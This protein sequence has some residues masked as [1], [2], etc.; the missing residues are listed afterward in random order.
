[1]ANHPDSDPLHYLEA[2]GTW[3]SSLQR[4]LLFMIQTLSS[5]KKDPKLWK[6]WSIPHYG[7]MQDLHHQPYQNPDLGSLLVS[8]LIRGFPI[9]GGPT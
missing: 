2:P 1:M 5:T 9:I 3:L 7:V 4:E 6:L 8:L